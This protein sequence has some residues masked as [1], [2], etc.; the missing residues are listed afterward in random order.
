MGMVLK[1]FLSLDLVRCRVASS[2]FRSDSLP[3]TVC[4][5]ALGSKYRRGR[6]AAKYSNVCAAGDMNCVSLSKVSQPLSNDPSW[7]MKKG[8]KYVDGDAW[9]NLPS[10]STRLSL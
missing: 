8:K 1:F 5:F 10:R 7:L 9:R 2:T 4:S 3:L 6:T